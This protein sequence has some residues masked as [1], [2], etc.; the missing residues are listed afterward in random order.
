MRLIHSSVCIT[1][2]GKASWSDEHHFL[3]GINNTER[4]VFNDGLKVLMCILNSVT[5]SIF[6]FSLKSFYQ[7]WQQWLT[8]RHRVSTVWCSNW[9][10]NNHQLQVGLGASESLRTITNHDKSESEWHLWSIHIFIKALYLTNRAKPGTA[11]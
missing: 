6:W 8:A 4:N 11:F 10:G 2:P 7:Y 9:D 1:A 3:C 5:Q